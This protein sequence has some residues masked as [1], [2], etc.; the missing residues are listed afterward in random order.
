MRTG[1]RRIALVAAA[2]VAV[3]LGAIGSPAHAAQT[4]VRAPVMPSIVMG[5]PIATSLT[6]LELFGGIYFVPG[7]TA[8]A[9]FVVHNATKD[10]GM[11]SLALDKASAADPTLLN[12]LRV[13]A[14]SPK[15]SA[16]ADAA[17]A[18][19]SQCPMLIPETP[20]AAGGD[21]TVTVSVSMDA[22][23]T[24]LQHSTQLS[25]FDFIADMHDAGSMIADASQICASNGTQVK[26]VPVPWASAP[27]VTPHSQT[28]G[29][30]TSHPGASGGG[31]GGGLAWTGANILIVLIV[32]ASLLA[33]GLGF[34]VAA[35]RRRE[36]PDAP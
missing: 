14:N 2:A 29:K 11:L 17:L 16:V 10:A 13:N 12:V 18:S 21:V 8:N 35:R 33:G 9:S 22:G 4:A 5:A 1:R 6:S 15:S 31:D 25:N 28:G 36:R 27:N 30:G 34:I 32:G 7:L 19:A 24:G 23:V 26:L 20:I 3:A